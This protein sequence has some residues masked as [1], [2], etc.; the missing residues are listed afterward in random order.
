MKGPR[1]AVIAQKKPSSKVLKARKAE[2]KP[3][4]EEA[5][6]RKKKNVSK[7]TDAPK[8]PASAFFIF[9]DEFRK[10]FKEKYP[11]NKAVSAVGK[12]GGEKWKSLSETD[13][14][15]YLEKALKR[16]A[17][18]EKVLEAYKQQKF[19]NNNKNNGGNE[20][21]EE[22]SEKSTSEVNNDDEQEASS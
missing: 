16:K 9:M 5:S 1:N 13:K 10:Y 17:E 7:D 2:S 18:Y 15:P 20:K 4:K 8:R 12:A 22:E 6:S 21:S 11:D 19:N 14:A 3:G